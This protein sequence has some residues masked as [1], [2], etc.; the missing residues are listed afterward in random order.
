MLAMAAGGVRSC[1]PAIARGRADATL[2]QS[3]DAPPASLVAAY[4]EWAGVDAA[5]FGATVPPHFIACQTAL[6]MISR[7]TARAP[8]PLLSVVNQGVHLD[9]LAPVPRGARMHL[10]GRLV[11]ASDDGTRARIHS[12][13][14]VGTDAQTEV[15]VIDAYAAVMLKSRAGRT[16]N[17][18]R[19]P[20]FR[21]V[22]RW[23]A[24]TDEGVTF[25]K[26]TGDFNPIHTLPLVARRTRFGGCIMHG[27]AS[28]AQVFE[29]IRNTGI[30]IRDI[31]V[32]FIRAVPLPSPVLAIQISEQPDDEGRYAVHMI[33][34]D[35]H[36]YQI[37]SFLPRQA[38]T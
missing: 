5:R 11:D 29:A 31:D 16:R 17:A 27:Y 3:A 10:E 15:M 26:L 35:E 14:H 2:T 13:V 21:T 6:A 4:S 8:Y 37:G 32:R 23:Q 24:A 36:T 38:T 19:T 1:L 25:F 34:D 33:D 18:P 7:L 9:L 22:G 28:F 30:D 12:R 20:A